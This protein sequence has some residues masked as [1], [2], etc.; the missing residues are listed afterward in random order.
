MTR[1]NRRLVP[2]AAAALASAALVVACDHPSRQVIS[3][4][5]E[6]YS[7]NAA[8]VSASEHPRDSD[9]AARVPTPRASL[10]PPESISDAAIT[11]KVR[12]AIHSDPGMAGADVSVNTD[13]GV[14]ILAGT[15][16]SHEQTGIASAHA[17]RQDGVMRIDNQLSIAPQ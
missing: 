7:R 9:A 3:T 6:N 10:P 12:G 15:V 17:Q 1:G 2:F 14:V 11:A 16:K 13:H 5:A 4:S 8:Q